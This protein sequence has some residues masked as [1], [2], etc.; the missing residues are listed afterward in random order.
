MP[1][2]AARRPVSQCVVMAFSSGLPAMNGASA[3]PAKGPGM[4][5]TEAAVMSRNATGFRAL[6]AKITVLKDKIQ[7]LQ[8]LTLL[9][10]EK[11][12]SGQ[13]RPEVF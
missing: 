13:S 5:A 2:G 9:G 8:R 3:G 4:R 7:P 12:R 6:I 11:P 1:Q 10:H